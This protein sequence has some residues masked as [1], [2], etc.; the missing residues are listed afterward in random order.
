M[1]RLCHWGVIDMCDF[2]SWIEFEKGIFFLTDNDLRGKKFKEFKVYNPGWRQDIMGHGAIR[3]WYPELE[4]RGI[5]KEMTNFS[6]P[7]NFPEEIAYAILEGKLTKFGMSVVLLTDTAWAEYEKIKDTALAEYGKIK[8][9]ALAEYRKIKDTAWAEYGKI[10]DTALA[11][12]RKITTRTFWG[13]FSKPEN[14][15]ESWRDL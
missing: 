1:S 3:F 14:R 5:K 12:Y 11:E 2:V 8:D 9:P 10:T 6:K 7:S 15:I 4:Y 13:L